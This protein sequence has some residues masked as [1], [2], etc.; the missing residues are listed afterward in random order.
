MFTKILENACNRHVAV[1]SQVAG[2]GGCSGCVA[3]LSCCFHLSCS[4]NTL[5][6]IQGVGIGLNTNSNLLLGSFIAGARE[7]CRRLIIICPHF[8]A[9]KQ[10]TIRD[11]ELIVREQYTSVQFICLENRARQGHT[12][13]RINEPIILSQ[14]FGMNATFICRGSNYQ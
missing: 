12:W 14:H 4:Q 5:A 3:L 9:G 11:L 1:W 10:L 2:R 8:V 7:C 13:P 6:G